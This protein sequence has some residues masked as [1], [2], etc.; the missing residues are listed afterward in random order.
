MID[1][2]LM[3]LAGVLAFIFGW[4][5]SSLL[6]GNIRAS[7]SFGTRG[8][9]A[10]AVVGL[11]AGVVVAGSEM[12]KSLDGSLAPSSPEAGLVATFVISIALTAGL[13]LLKLPATFSGI[14]VGSFLGAA[15]ALHLTVNVNQVLLVVSFWFLAPLISG[16]IAFVLRKATSSLLIGLS[17]VGVDSFNR[18]AILG[19]SLAVA[20]VLGANNIGL[21][22]GTAL[23]GAS[24]GGVP[25]AAGLALVAALGAAL[26]GKDHVSDTVGDKM[27]SLSPQGVFSVFAGA[28]IAVMAG[29]QLH[30]PLS[31]GESVLG[32]MFGAAYSQR[33]TVINRRVATVTLGMWLVTPLLAL[34]AAFVMAAA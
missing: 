24:S 4:N 6:I 8:A 26:L 12:L 18:L 2:E 9:V 10:L 34:L 25:L 16:V 20:F 28:A 17:L 30:I 11:L 1:T 21:I 33:T 15:T 13:T 23:G 22:A 27:L 29:T 32:G 19:T 14:M 7:G 3:V 5:N 31:I